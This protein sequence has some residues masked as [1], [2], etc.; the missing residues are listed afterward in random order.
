MTKRRCPPCR[1]QTQNWRETLQC[2]SCNTRFEFGVKICPQCGTKLDGNVGSKMTEKALGTSMRLP[3]PLPLTNPI[4]DD[5]DDAEA[6]PETPKPKKA[7]RKDEVSRK[8][9][10]EIPRA[11]KLKP[12]PAKPTQPEPMEFDLASDGLRAQLVERP[13]LL[14]PGLRIHSDSAG[15]PTGVDL[16]TEVGDIDILARDEEGHWVVVAVVDGEAD[17]T[18]VTDLLQRMGWVQKHLAEK[19]DQVRAIILLSSMPEDLGYAAAA[20]SDKLRF[21]TWQFELKLEDVVF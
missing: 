15:R 4:D 2:K 14:E 3:D 19:G 9:G 11:N 13:E 1:G 17:A 21:C 10:K 12:A 18:L 16:E 5:F 8:P 6:A 20:M 7:A